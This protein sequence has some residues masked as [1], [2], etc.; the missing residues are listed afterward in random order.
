MSDRHRMP[1]RATVAGIAMLSAALLGGCTDPVYSGEVTEPPEIAAVVDEEGMSDEDFRLLSRLQD[2]WDWLLLR[3]SD[4]NA[5]IDGARLGEWPPLTEENCCFLD[6]ER[7]PRLYVRMARVAMDFANAETGRSWEP[8][9]VEYPDAHSGEDDPGP[10]PVLRHENPENTGKHDGEQHVDTM[11]VERA[12]D[13]EVGYSICVQDYRWASPYRIGIAGRV[14][15]GRMDL[16]SMEDVEGEAEGIMGF[17][18]AIRRSGILGDVPFVCAYDEGGF[19]LDDVSE[20]FARRSQRVDVGFRSVGFQNRPGRDTGRL[21]VYAPSA[22][23]GDG[24]AAAHAIRE[25]LSGDGVTEVSLMLPFL[26]GDG[27]GAVTD[28]GVT[29]HG[30]TRWDGDDVT[31]GDVTVTP[32][33]ATKILARTQ[34]FEIRLDCP[35]SSLYVSK[36][37][38]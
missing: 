22:S 15:T 3:D 17:S 36:S 37:G 35:S 10:V 28:G 12:G 18:D 7:T 27:S 8:V 24:E 16:V 34:G 11:L 33:M 26:G 6:D 25:L 31:D 5:Y 29:L 21:F 13:G 38:D 4:A 32:E 20:G 19:D 14:A 23:V 9:H 1:V 30:W 2:S